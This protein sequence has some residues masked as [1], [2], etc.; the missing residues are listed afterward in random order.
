MEF[1]DLLDPGVS[2]WRSNSIQNGIELHLRCV[3]AAEGLL[4]ASWSALG[5]LLEPKKVGKSAVGRSWGALGGRFRKQLRAD[6]SGEEPRAPTEG[7]PG[8]DCP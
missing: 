5:G 1:H 2:F 6:G 7:T 8:V 3:I 4:K